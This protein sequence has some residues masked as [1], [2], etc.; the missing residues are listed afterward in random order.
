MNIKWEAKEYAEN[1]GFV[2]QKLFLIYRP[3]HTRKR[4]HQAKKNFLEKFKTA[5]QYGKNVFIKCKLP[6][7][8]KIL[9]FAHTL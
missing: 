7:W 3:K 4:I 8:I 6:M 5:S 2:P 1:F 9:T